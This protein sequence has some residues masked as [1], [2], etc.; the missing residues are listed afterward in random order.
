MICLFSRLFG[1]KGGVILHVDDSLQQISLSSGL[2]ISIDSKVTYCLT[3]VLSFKHSEGQ[4][5]PLRG[6]ERLY[7]SRNLIELE[8]HHGY[9]VY[10]VRGMFFSAAPCRRQPSKRRRK[11][12]EGEPNERSAGH[13]YCKIDVYATR[14]KSSTTATSVIVTLTW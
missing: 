1:S 8:H 14:T 2:A 4:S 10:T 7:P 5:P 11:K 6:V 12:W 13:K 9:L 3:G